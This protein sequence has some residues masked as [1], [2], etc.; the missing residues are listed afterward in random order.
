MFYGK[1]IK[2]L[3]FRIQELTQRAI[4]LAEKSNKL[5][6]AISA[7]TREIGE[8]YAL[9]NKENETPA[10]TPKPKKRRPMRKKNGEESKASTK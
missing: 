10:P 2:E 6:R 5:S 3:E 9:L 4:E 8:L 1:K 7:Q